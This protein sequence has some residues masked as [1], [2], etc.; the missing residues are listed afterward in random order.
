MNNAIR[1][2]LLKTN[3]GTVIVQQINQAN[4]VRV[5]E[6]IETVQSR[7]DKANRDAAI[8][9]QII[10]ESESRVNEAIEVVQD[11][12]D[13]RKRYLTLRELV[14][15]T[16]VTI[17]KSAGFKTHFEVFDQAKARIRDL[18]LDGG[19]EYDEVMTA[20][21]FAPASPEAF[22]TAVDVLLPLKTDH[23]VEDYESSDY[24]TRY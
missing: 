4:G 15:D 7:I 11:I 18:A 17:P 16:F 8:V 14:H 24:L 13:C 1:D 20:L 2:A 5:N 10:Q 6:D 21:K 23:S 19:D 12:I 22:K 3:E 9:Q